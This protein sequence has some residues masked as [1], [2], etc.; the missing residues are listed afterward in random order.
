MAVSIAAYAVYLTGFNIALSLNT[1]LNPPKG[2]MLGTILAISFILGI[3]HGAT[4]D[5]HTW[6]ITFSYAIGSYSTKKGAKAGLAFSAGF[7]AQRAFLTTLG[8]LGLAAIYRM[9]NLDGPIYVVVGIAMAAAGFYILNKRLDLHIPFDALLLGKSHHT[10]HAVRVQPH[11]TKHKNIPLSMA[12]VHGLIAGFGFGAYATVITFI[13]APQVP[14]LIYAPL[15]GLFFGL[16]TMLM[17]I[18]FGAIFANIAKVK[19]LTE[20]QVACVGRQ[21][22]GRTLLYGGI[23]FAIIGLLV[24]AFPVLNGIALQTGVPIPNLDSLGVATFLVLLVVGV[25]G[26]GSLILGVRRMLHTKEC[27]V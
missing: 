25:I 2:L 21:T 26:I 8:F 15:P 13:L 20:E 27:T 3:M 4:P 7:T 5:E 14:S 6:P 12:V 22:A 11:D 19:K 17:Q 9:Y 23:A 16:G 10:E 1:I 18:V 24:V